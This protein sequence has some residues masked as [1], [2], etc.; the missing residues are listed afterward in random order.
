MRTDQSYIQNL[1]TDELSAISL[2]HIYLLF[3]NRDRHLQ[4]KF[5]LA[6]RGMF[7]IQALEPD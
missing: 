4:I 1:T 6:F 7:K 5:H 2:A 3:K